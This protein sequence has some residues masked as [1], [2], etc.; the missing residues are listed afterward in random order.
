MK[1]TLLNQKGQFAIETVLMMIITIG[2]FMYGTKQL[3]EGKFLAKLISEPWQRVAGMIESGV[4]DTPE[5]A[6]LRHPNQI[7]RSLAVKPEEL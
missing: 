7:N 1:P 6:R 2:F 4:W 3:R 5:K